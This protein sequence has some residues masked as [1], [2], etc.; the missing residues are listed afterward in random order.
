[1]IKDYKM[2]KEVVMN[3]I[4]PTPLNEQS[5]ITNSYYQNQQDFIQTLAS[6]GVDNIPSIEV[7]PNQFQRFGKDKKY[8][9]LY[10]GNFGYFKDWSGE[11]PDITWFANAGNKLSFAERQELNNQIALEKKQREKELSDQYE[12]ASINANQ[13]WAALSSS[14]TSL[15]L[16]NKNL[17]AIDGI[18]FGS[19]TNGNFIA[20]ALTDNLNKIWSIQF[21]YENGFKKFI[22]NS[23][24]K[25][26]YGEF[27]NKQSNNV[28]ICEGLATGLSILLTIPDFLIVVAYN[29]HNLKEVAGNIKAK[30]PQKNI[31]IAGDNDLAKPSNIGKEKAEET[32]RELGLNLVLPT[33]KD[34]SSKP[35]DFDDL[36][37]LEGIG[38][39]KKQLSNL[40][41]N[42]DCSIFYEP[43]KPININDLEPIKQLDVDNYLPNELGDFIKDVAGRLC[44][45]SEFVAI[46]LIVGFSSL[47]AGKVAIKPKANDNFCIFPNLWGGLIGNPS[48]RKSDSLKEAMFF[49]STLETIASEEYQD[50]YS[51]YQRDLNKYKIKKQALEEQYKNQLKTG[52]S[53]MEIESKLDLLEEPKKVCLERF[54]INEASTQKITE[55]L[56]DNPN[57]SILLERDELAGFLSALDKK[58]NEADR[59]YFLEM[60]NGN[61]TVRS[62]TIGRGSIIAKNTAISIIGT[63]QPDKIKSYL[64]KALNGLND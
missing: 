37:Q 22:K 5:K 59:A 54:K 53:V 49:F 40:V 7:K 19:D 52:K 2:E 47:M 64:Q 56:R 9:V 25:G 50:N 63:T 10:D 18:K 38:E 24:T 41:E 44:V 45:P 16:Q 35:S 26:C 34:A 3:N 29:C 28:F 43:L 48:T 31:V 60:W 42:F 39:V 20:T 62:D 33:F 1:M 4:Q 14:G 15:Y 12:T 8:S 61:N 57:P 17:T 21:I 13:I 11:I 36:R 32:A 6:A 30:Y 46:P 55:I 23:K 51:Q 58:E 27:G